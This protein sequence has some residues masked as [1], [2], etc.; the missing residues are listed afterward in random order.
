MMIDHWPKKYSRTFSIGLHS[1]CLIQHG[2]KNLPFA[3]DKHIVVQKKLQFCYDLVP[4]KWWGNGS[5]F[6]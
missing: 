1:Y 5:E 2:M 6:Q 4:K 3:K